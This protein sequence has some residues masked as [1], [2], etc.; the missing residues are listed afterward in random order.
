MV[1]QTTHNYGRWLSKCQK[2]VYT[3]TRLNQV[4]VYEFWIQ[5]VW[6]KCLELLIL[7]NVFHNHEHDGFEYVYCS[8]PGR[9]FGKYEGFD[10]VC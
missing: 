2:F 7:H 4:E 5:G 3:G 8:G 1:G 10:A 9:F 6:Q